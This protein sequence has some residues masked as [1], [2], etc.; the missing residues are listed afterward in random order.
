MA[1]T[2]CLESIAMSI[3]QNCTSPLVKGYTGR[4]VIIPSANIT[5]LT[6]DSD[7]PRIL[8]AVTLVTTTGKVIAVDNIMN[9]PFSGSAKS[10]NA[11]NGY[12][13]FNKTLTVR[14]PLRGA[15]VSKDL[16]EPLMTNPEG[17]LV[18]VEKNDKAGAGSFEVLGLNSRMKASADGLTQNETDNGG[19]YVVTLS[20][21]EAWAE[22]E[23]MP[24][25]GTYAAAKA[26]FD[27][28]YATSY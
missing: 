16:I 7:N 2:S 28:L 8:E 9:D 22:A 17:F 6:Q 3:A 5:S 12:I 18:I 19:A 4:A 15:E 27:T 26:A 1:I 25:T 21:E 11:E 24:S 10:S 23:F 13:R 20:C 14:I